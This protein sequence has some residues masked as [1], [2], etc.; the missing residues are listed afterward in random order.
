MD[1][2]VAKMFLQI[3]DYFF[4]GGGVSRRSPAKEVPA[5]A[6]IN[7]RQAWTGSST[8]KAGLSWFKADPSLE[9]TGE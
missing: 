4:P 9:V 2:E 8:C 1:E 7:W 3:H 5:G 6:G